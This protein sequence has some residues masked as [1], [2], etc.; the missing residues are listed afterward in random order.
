MQTENFPL[1]YFLL[2]PPPKQSRRMRN[3]GPPLSLHNVGCSS[4]PDAAPAWAAASSRPHPLLHG[5]LHGCK[6]R[7]ALC[8]AQGLQGTAC[9]FLD[10]FCGLFPK[11]ALPEAH[12]ALLTAQRCVPVGAAGAGPALI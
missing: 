4:G 8:D 1:I 11:S 3:C 5:G 12:R 6:W 7:C 9:C 2:P 10:L